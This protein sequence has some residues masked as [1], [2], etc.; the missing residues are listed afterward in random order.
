M[1]L[2][3]WIVLSILLTCGLIHQKV[4]SGAMTTI[5]VYDKWKLLITEYKLVNVKI[6]KWKVDVLVYNKLLRR[7]ISFIRI[8]NN[9]YPSYLKVSQQY[10]YGRLPPVIKIYHISR[11]FLQSITID[12]S[13]TIFWNE[14]INSNRLKR[15]NVQ[16]K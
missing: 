15:N 6:N 3:E 12:I 8:S 13:E 5:I 11:M 14:C 16:V 10:N 2:E 4:V 9:N 1:L 7:D